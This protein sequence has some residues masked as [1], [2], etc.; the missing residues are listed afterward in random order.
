MVLAPGV[1][2]ESVTLRRAAV[3]RGEP[4]AVID[5][6]G[7]GT[8]VRIQAPGAALGIPLAVPA[9]WLARRRR[10]PA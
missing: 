4:G 7:T 6:G 10:R 1:Y 5:G 9:R 8:V 3:L 2:R